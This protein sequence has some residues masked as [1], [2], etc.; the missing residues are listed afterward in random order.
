MIAPF[1]CDCGGGRLFFIDAPGCRGKSEFPPPEEF[2]EESAT[3]M[4]SWSLSTSFSSSS[5]SSQDKM[6]PRGPRS[7]SSRPTSS[8]PSK[9]KVSVIIA[10]VY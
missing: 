9:A 4:R 10:A 2:L 6:E 8:L 1:G 7:L 5:E 3:P